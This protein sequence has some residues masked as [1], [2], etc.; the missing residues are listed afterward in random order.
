MSFQKNYQKHEIANSF[1]CN[2][3]NYVMLSTAKLLQDFWSAAVC[4]AAKRST[5]LTDNRI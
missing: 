3:Y 2:Q 5:I 1:D 4:D